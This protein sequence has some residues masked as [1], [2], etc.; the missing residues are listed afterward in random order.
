MASV[1]TALISDLHLGIRTKADLLAR[2][3]I[4]E[5]L[6]T[7]LQPVDH[8][9]LL[10]DSIELRDGPP[11]EALK[12]ARPFF[13]ALGEAMA[14]GRV[15]VVAGN[16]DHQL[17]SAWIARRPPGRPLGLEELSEPRPG[18][19]LSEL[20]ARMGATELVLAY[21]GLWLRPDIYATHGH[22]LDCHNRALTFECVACAAMARARR[23]REFH[24]P[25]DYEAVVRPVYR[26]IYR[27]A[28]SRRARR[29]AGTAKAAVRWS[30]LRAGVR[31]HGTRAGSGVKAMGQ[32][33]E[34]LAIDADH[35]IFGHLHHP[36]RWEGPSGATLVNAGS[37]LV[38]P[39]SQP[40]T[41]VIVREGGSP[42]LN[43]VIPR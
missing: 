36:G 20:A 14:G 4:R 13:E 17:A 35:V 31:G 34:R 29:A 37:W 41:C 16:H 12:A 10:G 32:V 8:L 42:E 15:T 11:E 6:I 19:P 38:E 40:G 9:V 7:A 21:P 2:P 1:V 18:D 30:E 5:A 33:V 24:A 27:I 39:D 3:E 26:L 23:V 22:Y 25:D 28:Q 43:C